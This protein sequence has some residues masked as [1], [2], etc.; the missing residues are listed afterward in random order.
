MSELISEIFQIRVA[1]PILLFG[2][3]L[4]GWDGL[5]NQSNN[6]PF[7]SI[8]ITCAKEQEWFDKQ[9]L[10]KVQIFHNSKLKLVGNFKV[11]KN[12]YSGLTVIDRI[13]REYGSIKNSPSERAWGWLKEKINKLDYNSRVIAIPSKKLLD[14]HKDARMDFYDLV[15]GEYYLSLPLQ[16][17]ILIA[18]IGPEPLKIDPY[19]ISKDFKTTPIKQPAAD[20]I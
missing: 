11:T 5:K 15:K 8:F 12:K 19:P 13:E 7:F 14:E 4:L 17:K 16:S 2:I 18:D 9:D 20:G 1:I 3:F 6:R 10:I